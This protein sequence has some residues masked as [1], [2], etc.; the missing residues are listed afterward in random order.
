MAIGTAIFVLGLIWLLIVYRGFRQIVLWLALLALLGGALVLGNEF[1]QKKKYECTD[2]IPY[3][4]DTGKVHP[5]TPDPFCNV[6]LQFEAEV[7]IIGT[8]IF[9]I[10]I[11]A[12]LIV[13]GRF[14]WLATLPLLAGGL[15]IGYSTYQQEPMTLE[16][17][18][19]HPT[20]IGG[21]L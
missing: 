17:S 15:L 16:R 3:I 19:C 1:Y 13:R 20:T 18:V 21:V 10:G 7:A 2:I 8:V 14:R 11:L 5:I 9:V 4:D 6:I 12:L